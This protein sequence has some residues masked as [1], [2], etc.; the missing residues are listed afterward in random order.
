M[1]PWWSWLLSGTGFLWPSIGIVL[2]KTSP[3]YDC[4]REAGEIQKRDRRDLVLLEAW[5]AP[6]AGVVVV[7]Q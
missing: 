3:N 5:L 1:V 7:D 4:L 2:S 6:V